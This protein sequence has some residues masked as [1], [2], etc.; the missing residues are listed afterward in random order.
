[1]CGALPA[2]TEDVTFEFLAVDA[3]FMR[4]VSEHL[5]LVVI[6]IC[7]AVGGWRSK[8]RRQYLYKLIL[9]AWRDHGKFNKAKILVNPGASV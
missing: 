1:M 2:A 6:I 8:R 5:L 3:P 4:Y 7:L 9:F